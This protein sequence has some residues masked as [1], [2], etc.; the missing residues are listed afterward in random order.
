MISL[1][2]RIDDCQNMA[3]VIIGNAGNV[4]GYCCEHRYKA[5]LYVQFDSN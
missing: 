5:D 3:I 1:F 2:C 4:I